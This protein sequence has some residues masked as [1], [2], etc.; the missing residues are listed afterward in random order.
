MFLMEYNLSPFGFKNK[1][2][3]KNKKK[4][5]LIKCSKVLMLM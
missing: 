2:S 4:L 1:I 3:K 5:M